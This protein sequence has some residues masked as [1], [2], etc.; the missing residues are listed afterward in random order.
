MKR[1]ALALGAV[2]VCTAA[3]LPAS[4]STVSLAIDPTYGSTESTGATAAVVLEFTQVGFEE[5]LSVTIENT[6]PLDIGS[7]LTAVGLEF[8][9]TLSLAAELAPGGASAYFDE[10]TFGVSVS[11][12][13]LDA[14]GGYDLLI[15]SDGNF[16]GGS[17]RGAPL[18]GESQSVL[19]SLGDTLL[20]PI[21]LA[22]AFADFYAGTSG[23]FSI[24]RFQAVGP[25]GEWSDK[26]GGHTPEPSTALLLGL[27]S[28]VLLTRRPVRA[29]YGQ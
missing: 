6:T 26:V 4:G 7:S 3:A 5:F 11:P 9:D 17:P 16:E 24:A 20:A 14:P 29:T 23:R 18:A 13:W 21:D 27:G 10:L 22:I 25:D 8:P 19:L 2:V 12:G 1:S 15:S 28:I